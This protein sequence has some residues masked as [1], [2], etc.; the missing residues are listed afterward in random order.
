MVLAYGRL[1]CGS[2]DGSVRRTDTVVGDTV[3][4]SMSY[5]STFPVSKRLR[6]RQRTRC[7]A[8]ATQTQRRTRITL[9][10]SLFRVM[11]TCC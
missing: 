6:R 8:Q 2:L 9:C 11:R 4:G 10:R 7:C 5:R 3:V 1:G